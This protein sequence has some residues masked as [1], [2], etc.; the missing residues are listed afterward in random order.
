MQYP[1]PV[2]YRQV[3]K[4]PRKAVRLAPRLLNAMVK[5]AIGR[6]AEAKEVLNQFNFTFNATT[7]ITQALNLVAE[8]TDYNSRIGR[9]VT[10][11]YLEISLGMI[12]VP[13][14]TGIAS[15]GD[16]G[17]WTIVLDRQPNGA[18][19]T[20]NVIF[21]S[22]TGLGNRITSINQDRFKIIA[23]EEF[24]I[25][26]NVNASTGTQNGSGAVPYHIRRFVDL[27]KLKGQDGKTKFMGTGATVGDVDEGVLLFCMGTT[28]TTATV[29]TLLN[30]NIKYRFTDM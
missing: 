11:K 29:N 7:N 25:G 23:S 13:T 20:Y 2:P 19:A 12:C 27:S 9:S 8:G 16:Y 22:A 28:L 6:A 4:K 24:A 21:D 15:N 3:S 1:S 17:R 30:A 26:G 10:H 14:T 18:L 5:K